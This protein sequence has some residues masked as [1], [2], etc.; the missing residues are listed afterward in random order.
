MLYKKKRKESFLN[1]RIKQRMY[2]SLTL[3][4]KTNTNACLD[5][6]LF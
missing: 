3:K 6:H 2:M 1:D 5:E 4:I